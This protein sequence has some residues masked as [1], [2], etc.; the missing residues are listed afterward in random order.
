MKETQSASLASQSFVFEVD[1][2]QELKSY[3]DDVASRLPLGDRETL[4]DVEYRFAEIFSEKLSSPMMVVTL[5]MVGEATA[6]MGSP[7]AFGEPRGGASTEEAEEPQRVRGRLC[8][9]RT[10]RSIAG[11]CGGLA[12]YFRIDATLLR[13]VTLLLILFGGLSIWFYII[14]WILLPEEPL[15]AEGNRAAGC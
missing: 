9:S 12:A 7:A 13:L 1:A 6:Q 11:V 10:N 2:Y 3:L 5:R 15:T 14:L 4:E 8:R